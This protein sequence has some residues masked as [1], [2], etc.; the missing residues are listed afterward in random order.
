MKTIISFTIGLFILTSCFNKHVYDSYKHQKYFV[1]QTNPRDSITEPGINEYQEAF[2][3]YLMSLSEEERQEWV[4]GTFTEE[5]VYQ[6]LDTI[7]ANGGTE[8]KL[9]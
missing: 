7:K 5:E 1:N 4:S 8:I 9:K 2:A 6:F 3:I